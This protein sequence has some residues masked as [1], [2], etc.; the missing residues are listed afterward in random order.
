MEPRTGRAAAEELIPIGRFARLTGLSVG[1]LRHYDELD[2]LRPVEVDRFTGYR[3]YAPEQLEVAR[4]IARLRDLEVPLEEIRAVLDTDDP[5]EQRRRVGDQ[6]A[7]VQARLDRQAHI[8]HV[9]RQLSQGREPIVTST[10]AGTALDTLDEAAHR[11]LGKDLYNLAWTLMEK[12][13]RTPAEDDE[14][15]QAAHASAFHW[16]RGG[17]TL[18]NAAR[19]QWQIARVYSAL[20]RGE[21][22]VWHAQRCLALAEAAVAAGVADDWDLPAALEGLARA[23]AVAGDRAGAVATHKRAL[24]SLAGIADPEDRQLIEDDL[25]TTPL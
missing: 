17:G 24:E 16:S 10:A 20:G 11:Q 5:A 1:A 12:P 6:A 9:L 3:R 4:A 19:G 25:K 22:A 2:L 13:D 18:A 15:V 21:P 8:L 23:Q 7:R 14:L